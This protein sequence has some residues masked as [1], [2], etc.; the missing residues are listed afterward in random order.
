MTASIFQRIAKAALRPPAEECRERRGR[1]KGASRAYVAVPF[2]L[3]EHLSA[4]RSAWLGIADRPR[5]S[6]SADCCCVYS[7]RCQYK[8]S[9]LATSPATLEELALTAGP[10]HGTPDRSCC[11]THSTC[12]WLGF[13][14]AKPNPVHLGG[15]VCLSRPPNPTAHG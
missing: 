7:S 1:E 4:R 9:S 3:S 6:L 12:S 8:Y 14:D 2:P 10:G 11:V 15:L 13:R 5:N